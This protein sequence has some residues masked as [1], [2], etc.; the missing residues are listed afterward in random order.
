V[1]SCAGNVLYG[2]G[3]HRHQ[4]AGGDAGPSANTTEGLYERKGSNSLWFH[5]HSC[6]PKYLPESV[7]GLGFPG[8]DASRRGLTCES[9]RP[10]C[11]NR[12]SGSCGFL[13]SDVALC[14]PSLQQLV[15]LTLK[16]ATPA[17]AAG[18]LACKHP[19]APVR[20]LCCDRI[21]IS[22][23]SRPLRRHPLVPT[24]R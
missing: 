13:L 24:P 2:H 17:S 6:W 8:R 22:I 21:L 20:C 9:A 23:A 10:S 11:K 15:V 18:P 12:L 5:F 14:G 3:S 19:L 1:A 16:Q 4:I 7:F